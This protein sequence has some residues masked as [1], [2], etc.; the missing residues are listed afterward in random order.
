MSLAP[1]APLYVTHVLPPISTCRFA[2]LC[3]SRPRGSIRSLPLGST[4]TT[5]V[6]SGDPTPRPDRSARSLHSPKLRRIERLWSQGRTKEPR[7]ERFSR[8]RAASN[9]RKPLLYLFSSRPGSS[10]NSP[11]LN[12]IDDFEVKGVA[13]L[14]D[15]GMEL[16]DLFRVLRRLVRAR[17]MII[18]E[19]VVKD[20]QFRG[21]GSLCPYSFGVGLL[22]V[23]TLLHIR[24]E[25]LQ[26]KSAIQVPFR[27]PGIDRFQVILP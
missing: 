27:I 21:E 2:H 1:V 20:D 12:A 5:L 10:A 15:G 11:L 13:I 17:P 9:E 6:P 24:S 16:L 8:S 22:V 26:N 4:A 23:E 19:L 7:R 18:G 3:R 25:L 14:R